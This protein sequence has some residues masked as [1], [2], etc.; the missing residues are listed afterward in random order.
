ME[1][2]AVAEGTALQPLRQLLG[3]H[4]KVLKYGL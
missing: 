3:K 1:E 4:I 2:V